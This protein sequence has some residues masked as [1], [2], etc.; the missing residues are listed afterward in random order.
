MCCPFSFDWCKHLCNWY[1]LQD[2]VL[3]A[4]E[5]SSLCPFPISIHMPIHEKIA[6]IV[7]TFVCSSITP[8]ETYSVYAFM[9]DFFYSACLRFTHVVMCIS[10]LFLSCWVY[11]VTMPQFVY[12]F[13]CWWTP[14]L[15]PD[16]GYYESSYYEHSILVYMLPKQALLWTFLYRVLCVYICMDI[17]SLLLNKYL[18]VEFVPRLYVY[19]PFK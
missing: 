8:E 4:L 15:F 18:E 14:V 2:R 3:T 1:S 6:I 5:K 13:S 11:H 10:S 16:L 19:L 7:F 12:L 9:F 17:Y